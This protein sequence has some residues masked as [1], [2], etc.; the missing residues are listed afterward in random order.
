MD[1]A[2]NRARR[3]GVSTEGRGRGEEREDNQQRLIVACFRRGDPSAS[4]FHHSGDQGTRK[5]TEE[6]ST[7]I[8]HGL[9]FSED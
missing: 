7:L 5:G 6:V 1:S 8:A 2:L 4:H 3:A 9:E